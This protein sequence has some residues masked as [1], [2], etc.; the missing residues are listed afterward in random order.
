MRRGGVLAVRNKESKLAEKT[1]Q[2]NAIARFSRETM[3]E[4]RRV[5]WPTREEAIHLT[6]IVLIV[7]FVMA[8]ILGLVDEIGFWLVSLALGVGTR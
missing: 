8:L 5:S 3:G 6:I 2:P 1:N 4:I 7:L